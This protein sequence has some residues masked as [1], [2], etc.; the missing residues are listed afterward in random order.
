MKKYLLILLLVLLLSACGAEPAPAGS[1]SAQ[2]AALQDV[3]AAY[4]GKT[5]PVGQDVEAVSRGRDSFQSACSSCHGESG[6]GDGP[7]ASSLVP[8]P[9]NL[10]DLAKTAKDDYLLWRI[11]EGK[12]G[13]AMVAWNSVLTEAQIWDLVAYIRSLE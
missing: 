9:V 11:A 2:P 4:A 6:K 3:P 1:D 10:V 8:P 5:N 7:A 12:N 13:T